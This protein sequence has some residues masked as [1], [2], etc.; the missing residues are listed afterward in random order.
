MWIVRLIAAP[1]NFDCYLFSWPNL[2]FR[3]FLLLLSTFFLRPI[4][5]L[6]SS[7]LLLHCGGMEMV[8]NRMCK[9][10]YSDLNKDIV[11]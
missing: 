9:H 7:S 4:L 10:V 11:S 8:I 6:F 5:F 2:F 3:R 1:F